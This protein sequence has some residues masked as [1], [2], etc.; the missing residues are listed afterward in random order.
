MRPEPIAD[1]LAH[2]PQRI[3]LHADRQRIG[4]QRFRWLGAERH[5][6]SGRER[7]DHAQRRHFVPARADLGKANQDIDLIGSP[8]SH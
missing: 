8:R 1:D 6:N 7:H 5:Q 3:L 4:L 2:E